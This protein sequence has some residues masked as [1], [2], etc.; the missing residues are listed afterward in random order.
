MV[1]MMAETHYPSHKHAGAEELY[2]LDGDLFVDDMT[3]RA[4]DYCRGETCSIHKEI[5]TKNGCLFVVTS[6]SDED[7]VLV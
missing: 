3:M 5:A 6:S 2:L 7:Q 1:R 4:G